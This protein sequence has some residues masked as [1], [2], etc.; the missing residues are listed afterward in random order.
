[1]ELQTAGEIKSMQSA[2]E[3]AL[4]EQRIAAALTAT[5]SLVQYG[6]LSWTFFS[7]GEL[8]VRLRAMM[9]MIMLQEPGRTAMASP[10]ML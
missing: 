7:T 8:A 10:V 4:R 2:H 1:M 6:L 9:G 5:L 3:R